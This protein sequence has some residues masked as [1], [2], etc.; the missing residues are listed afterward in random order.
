[1]SERPLWPSS[2]RSHGQQQETGTPF[3]HKSQSKLWRQHMGENQ[4]EIS[5]FQLGIF[6]Y[7]FIF[8][9]MYKVCTQS[10]Q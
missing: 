3:I 10:V 7:L 8:F 1:M 6:F 2:S 5:L 9:F 4:Y